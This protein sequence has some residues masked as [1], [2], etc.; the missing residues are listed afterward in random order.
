M[1]APQKD[2]H[3]PRLREAHCH[4]HAHGQA[5]AM[6]SLDRCRSLPECLDALERA[7]RASPRQG[8]LLARSARPESWPE[9]RW[10]TRSELH[11]A[12]PDLPL[13]IWCFDHHALCANPRALAIAGVTRAT[14]DPEGGVVERDPSG[15]PTGL[16]LEAATRLVWS[17]VPEPTPEQRKAHVHLALQDLAAK[18]FIEAHDMLSHDWLGPILA[19][20]RREAGSDGLPCAVHLYPLVQDL[21]RIASTRTSWESA[22][23]RLAGGKVFTDGTINSRTA[24]MLQPYADPIPSHPRGT[25]LMSVEQIAGAIRTCTDHGLHLAAHAI[26]DGAVRACL[27]AA[28]VVHSSSPLRSSSGPLRSVTSLRIEHAEL[29]DETDV[30]RFAKLGVVASVQPCHLLADIEALRRLLPHRLSRVLPL[31]ELIDAGCGPGELLWFGS[32]TPIV[33]PDAEDSIR[34]A[35]HRRRPDMPADEAISPEQAIAE[36]EA[37]GAFC[38]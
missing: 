34:A 5:A 27:D 2:A 33:R 6:V 4:L 20:L 17:I 11:Q 24:W 29:I 38:C 30:P 26:G 23:V 15:E 16:M 9:H 14:P 35:V 12:C 3:P 18:G 28:E 37:W 1:P 31:R 32:D 10:P 25:P 13:V 36:P 19:E 7:A 22:E 8:W 21:E